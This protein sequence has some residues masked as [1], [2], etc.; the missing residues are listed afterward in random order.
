MLSV[1]S[2]LK[3]RIL[4]LTGS[5][6]TLLMLLI[7]FVLLLKWREIIIQKQ[8]ENAVSISRTFAVTV[9]DALIFEEKSVY[10]KENI[11]ETYV[12]N[13]ISRLG[14]VQYVVI[15]DKN[16]TSIIQITNH[17]NYAPSFSFDPGTPAAHA[18]EI[19]IYD[20]PQFGWTMEVRQP[21]IFSG[22][23]WGTATIGFDAQPIRDEIAS[24]FIIL[25]VATILVTSIVLL[26]L[27]I[28]IRRMT[29]SLE[30]L[31]HVIDS[32]DF[33]PDVQIELPRRQ[34]E[35]GFFYNHFQSLQGRLESSKK[36]LEQAQKQIYQAE[37]LASIGRL[38]SGVAHQVNNPLNGIKSCLYA[39]Q[40]N[41]NNGQKTGEYLNLINEGI[42]DIETIVKK[43]LGFA[44]QQ[45]T[46]ESLININDAIHKVLN[47]FELRLKEKQID[48]QTD[49]AG[50]I[51]EV[52]IDSHL[53]QEVVMNLVLNSYDAIEK[54]GS[55]TITT[56]N[57]DSKHVFMEIRDS[58]AGISPDD[59]KKIFDPFFTTKDVGT[60]TGLGLSV[61]MGIIES[62]G[63]RIDVQSTQNVET[64]FTIQLPVAYEDE[65]ADH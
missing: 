1:R 17:S 36:E 13:F 7:S 16:G 9:V 5:V 14:N 62:H 18:K 48:V 49:L 31:V 33:S 58:G 4:L 47:L 43:L 64:I 27:F 26:I 10:K 34:D 3:T 46:S 20:N 63:G 25:L 35:I 8:S 22:K 50:E 38:A 61:C 56:G 23:H 44:R 40:Q 37:K 2:S 52:R 28:S 51:G 32:I 42:E 15:F 41:A 54:N 12:E 6:I 53:F 45:S 55:I 21:L 11:L 65:A 19:K 39:I 24:V 57:N 60:G 29:S 30:Q 59:L